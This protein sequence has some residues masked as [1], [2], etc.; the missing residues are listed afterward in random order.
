MAARPNLFVYLTSIG[1]EASG[2]AGRLG[3]NTGE[4]GGGH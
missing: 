4:V 3:V 1:S 2:G